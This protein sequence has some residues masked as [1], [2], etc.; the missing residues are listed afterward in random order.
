MVMNE[1]NEP[2]TALVMNRIDQ[3]VHRV[4]TPCADPILELDSQE[5]RIKEAVDILS[6]LIVIAESKQPDNLPGSPGRGGQYDAAS[7]EPGKS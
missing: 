3:T 6:L 7:G 1:L 2:G 5:T 4:R